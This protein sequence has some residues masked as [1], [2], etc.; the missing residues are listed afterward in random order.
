MRMPSGHLH[1]GSYG[2]TQLIFELKAENVIVM[3][4][5]IL[6]GTQIMTPFKQVHIAKH[7]IL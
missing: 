2:C 5:S 6:A 4:H 7:N 1:L 3:Y